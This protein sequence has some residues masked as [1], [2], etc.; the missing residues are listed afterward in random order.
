LNI[1]KTLGNVRQWNFCLHTMINI[2][3]GA[4]CVTIERQAEAL[5]PETDV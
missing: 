1:S 3:N 5:E 4:N 2:E